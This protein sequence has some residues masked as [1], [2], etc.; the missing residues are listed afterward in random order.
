MDDDDTEETTPTK[1]DDPEAPPPPPRKKGPSEF[2]KGIQRAG[3]TLSFTW[4]YL[5]IILGALLSVGLLLN[6]LGYG[7]QVTE[8]GLVI[9][10]L[11]NMREAQQF[12]KAVVE[13]MKDVQN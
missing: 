9:D 12:Q 4:S 13:S 5:N 8:H 3:L 2:I 1:D 11:G 10:T 7:Y 6:V